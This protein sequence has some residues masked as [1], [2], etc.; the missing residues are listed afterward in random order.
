[1]KLAA[2]LSLAL[3]TSLVA[4]RPQITTV[5]DHC[6]PVTCEPCDAERCAAMASAECRWAKGGTAV[7]LSYC[8]VH[9]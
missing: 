4:K 8:E 7:A 9:R 1:M 3:L 2:L 5:L 6:A